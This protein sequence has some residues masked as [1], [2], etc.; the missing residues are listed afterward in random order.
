MRKTFVR[1][2]PLAMV[3]VLIVGLAFGAAA[4]DSGASMGTVVCDSDLILNLYVAEYY[5]GY[6]V[7]HNAMMSAEGDDMM[8]LDLAAFDKGQYASLFDSMMAMMGDDMMMTFVLS[9]EQLVT[10]GEYMEMGMDGM[11]SMMGDDTMME[12]MTTLV[13][14]VVEGEA[15]ECTAL[16]ANLN[17]FHTAVAYSSMMM[18][19]EGQ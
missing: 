14:A 6:G 19:S 8:G 5:F 1:L 9:E 17:L 13:P 18:M 4:Q 12:G 7:V 16:R 15:A 11:M 2:V 10:V 3:A